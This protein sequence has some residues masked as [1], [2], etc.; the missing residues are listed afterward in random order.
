MFASAIRATLL[1]CR[2]INLT[3]RIVYVGN[4]PLVL[5]HARALLASSEEG[6]TAYIH[7]DLRSPGEILSSPVVREVPD[8][9]QPRPRSNAVARHRWGRPGLRRPGVRA[10]PPP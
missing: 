8:F 5:A 2:A 3:A 10:R 6:R 7:A 1:T 4:Y 9:S